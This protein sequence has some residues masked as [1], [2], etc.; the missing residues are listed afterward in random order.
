MSNIDLDIRKGLY[1][2]L[3]AAANTFRTAI[4]QTVGATTFYKLFDEEAPQ[5]FPGTTTDVKPPYVVMDILPITPARDSADTIETCSVAF[6][7]CSLTKIECGNIAG[8][9]ADRLD[10]CELSLSIGTFKVVRIQKEFQMRL[11]RLDLVYNIVVQ[12][13][14]TIQH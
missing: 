3:T 7:I 14:L 9:L 11:P 6:N 4:A 10:D 8:L 13:S 1:E 12:Y 5:Q 2:R